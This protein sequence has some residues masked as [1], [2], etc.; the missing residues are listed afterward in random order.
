M[1]E[2]IVGARTSSKEVRRI[3]MCS[4]QLRDEDWQPKKE[5][6]KMINEEGDK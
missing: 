2:G 6:R 5:T 3:G 1:K 4:S